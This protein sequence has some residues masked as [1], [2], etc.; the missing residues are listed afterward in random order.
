[1]SGFWLVSYIVLWIV[2]VVQAVGLFS[3][4][5]HFG[6]LYAKSREGRAAQGPA[7]GSFL[8]IA[9]T[10]DVHGTPVRWP[11]AGT[12][13]VLL[14]FGT[15]CSI[16]AAL[17]AMV[18]PRLLERHPDVSFVVLC[19]G[20]RDDVRRWAQDVPDGVPVVPDPRFRIAAKHQIALT[21]FAVAVGPDGTVR[22]RGGASNEGL[23]ESAVTAARGEQDGGAIAVTKVPSRVEEIT[24]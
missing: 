10:P 11:V 4:F 8:G 14:F 16:C 2:V 3:L 18:L 20:P 19:G 6:S 13:T 17:K 21:P 24:T 12:P 7:V 1:M 22:S 15:D 23:L 9:E 5:H